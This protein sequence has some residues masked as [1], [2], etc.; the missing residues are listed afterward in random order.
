[1]E[2]SD[3]EGVWGGGGASWVG[4]YCRDEGKIWKEL[5][6]HKYRTKNPNVLCC[7]DVGASNFWQG[8]MCAARVVRMGYRWKVGDGT[9]IKFWE[10]MWLGSHSLA[11]QYWEVYSI[12]NEQNKTIAELWDG[13]NL[14]CTFR[15]CVDRSL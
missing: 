13:S 3:Y 1:L 11:I 4:R 8:V 9:K 12:V 6:D 2:V 14:K 7:M 15:R 10:D 5:V